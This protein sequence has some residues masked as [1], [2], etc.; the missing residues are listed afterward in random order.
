MKVQT[1]WNNNFNNKNNDITIFKKWVGDKNALLIA[2]RIGA[3]GANYGAKITCPACNTNSEFSF[4]L[5]SLNRIGPDNLA[6]TID[7]VEVT[8]N[9]T[10]MIT[11]PK[12][13]AVFE[14]RPR[15]G[16]D[17]TALAEQEKRYKK[18]KINRK[19]TLTDN[20]I[21]VT[22]SVNGNQDPAH[23]RRVYENLPA[24]DFRH[25][26]K[27]YQDCMP[28]LDMRSIFECTACG[29]EEVVSVPMNADFFWPDLR[30]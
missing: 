11:V 2:A 18:L 22:L 12:T 26:R 6:L 17:D 4:D 13:G 24:F 1:Y 20:F 5:N 15:I 23:I 25:I 19:N 9:N 14:M 27:V 29:T 8:E 30:V 16:A 7:D 10:L 3:Y 28:N 21:M